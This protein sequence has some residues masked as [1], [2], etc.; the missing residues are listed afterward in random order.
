MYASFCFSRTTPWTIADASTYWN[1]DTL[2]YCLH[3]CSYAFNDKIPGSNVCTLHF[4][5]SILELPS[6]YWFPTRGR[7][8]KQKKI[9]CSTTGAVETGLHSRPFSIAVS[10][11]IGLYTLQVALCHLLKIHMSKVKILATR[12]SIAWDT[13]D[14]VSRYGLTYAHME[15]AS[16]AAWI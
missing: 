15:T 3:F 11:I 13:S 10:R 14:S 1:Y 5:L 2:K 16:R 12:N 6:N 4:S 8:E 7:A 9:S